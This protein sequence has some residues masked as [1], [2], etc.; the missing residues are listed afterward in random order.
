M[1]AGLGDENGLGVED[2]RV[3][4]VHQV[5]IVVVVGPNGEP[6]DGKL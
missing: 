6:M 3:K 4:E 1:E 2:S 5:G